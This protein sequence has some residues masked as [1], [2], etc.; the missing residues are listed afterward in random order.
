MELKLSKVW[1]SCLVE[2]NSLEMILVP[3]RNEGWDDVE[4]NLPELLS[5]S[6][7]S[8]IWFIIWRGAVV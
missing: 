6:P 4:F 3:P 7:D 2:R 8:L 1:L 5:F